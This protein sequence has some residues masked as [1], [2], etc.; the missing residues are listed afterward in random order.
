MSDALKEEITTVRQNPPY[1]G[2]ARIHA[3][4][5][6]LYAEGR[7][8]EPVPSIRAIGRHLEKVRDMGPEEKRR[9][10]EAHW[11]ESFGGR[12]LPW[13]AAP[14]V[15]ELTKTLRR[16]PLIPLAVWFWRV[17]AAFP[18]ESIEH[19]HRL[20]MNMA[21]GDNDPA[22]LQALG[23]AAVRGEFPGPSIRVGGDQTAAQAV[24]AIELGTGAMS[25]WVRQSIA[26][27]LEEMGDHP[28]GRIPGLAEHLREGGVMRLP[29]LA[30]R[31]S[32]E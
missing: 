26:E 25:V 3:A 6:K 22:R 12:D 8:G 29:G 18:N 14:A 21:I 27:V 20:A 17:S 15:I 28:T 31:V 11:P 32:H 5:E 1:P 19:R 30:E 13:E 2:A 9:Y 23:D 4:L 7:L 16:A 24:E 10:R